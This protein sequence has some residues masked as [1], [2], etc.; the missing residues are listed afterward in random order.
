MDIKMEMILNRNE[1]YTRI[2]DEVKRAGRII[3]E[4]HN[5]QETI[6]DK[7]G[8]ANFVTKYDKQVQN[9]LV[10]RFR[11]I[12]PEASYLAEEEGLQQS[13]EKGFCFII[14]PIDGTTNFIHEYMHSCI[15]VGLSYDGEM[16]MG[17]VYNPY[18]DEIFTA[19]KGQGAYKNGEKIEAGTRPLEESIVAFGCARYNSEDTDQA[20][21]LAKGLYV[22]SR[23]L[24]N[25]GS[26][27]LDICDVA[28]GRNGI[29]FELMLQPW[30]Y[31]AASLILEEAGGCITQID[32]QAITLDRPCSILAGSEQ[33]YKEAMDIIRIL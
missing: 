15:S 22:K 23:G 12:L 21:A 26:S 29:Y 25:R 5:N 13:M 24:R 11:E 10:G 19:I 3:V 17:V 18:R 28:C 27:T 9:Y 16:V 7:E 1:V 33:C 2:I 8:F 31:A 14:D 32:G 4:A 6:F 20:F 30:D